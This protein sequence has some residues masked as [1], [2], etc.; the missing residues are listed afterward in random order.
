[1]KNSKYII[2]LAA[3]YLSI[4]ACKKED[5]PSPNVSEID[6][7][8]SGSITLKFDNRM[9]SVNLVL[10]SG[11]YTNANNQKFTVSKFNYFIS[12][13]ILL[14]EDGTEYTVPQ[15]SSYFLIKEDD[16]S[17]QDV[18]INNIPEGNYTGV[19]LTIGV[20]SLRNT[21][22]LT[23]RTGDLDPAGAAA[24]MYWTWNSGYIFLKMEGSFLDTGSYIY[25]IGGFG[26]YSSNT[27]NNIKNVNLSFGSTAAEIREAHGAEGPE[28]HMFVD[29]MKVVNGSTNLNFVT[30]PVVMFSNY[31]LNISANYQSMIKVDHIHNHEH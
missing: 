9:G 10:D 11:E 5:D 30:N 8:R 28:I 13:V 14:N 2:L 26:G 27:I 6:P 17:T 4:S 31:S 23:E 3:L 25:H 24:G 7:N 22:P 21:K 19:K 20:D 18:V 1:M 16:M 29:G 15:D 12:N